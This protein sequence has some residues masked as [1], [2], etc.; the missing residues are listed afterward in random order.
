MT[1]RLIA[2]A[3]WKMNLDAAAKAQHAAAL[4]PAFA[5]F[6]AIDMLVLPPFTSLH[7]AR[8]VFLSSAVGIGGQNIYWDTS[9][10][11]TGEISAPICLVEARCRYVELAHSERLVS[12]SARPTNVFAARSTRQRRRA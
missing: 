9:G 7:A 10:A 8:Q 3:G 11:W 12:I 1:R 5:A 4:T 6:A 2:G